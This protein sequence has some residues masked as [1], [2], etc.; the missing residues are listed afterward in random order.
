[1]PGKSTYIGK[2]IVRKHLLKLMIY[3]TKIQR[4]LFKGLGKS[5]ISMS[6]CKL[7]ELLQ[8]IEFSGGEIETY[9]HK[10][11]NSFNFLGEE[12]VCGEG[13]DD[14][15]RSAIEQAPEEYVSLP[16]RFDIN[17]YKM[18]EKFIDRLKDEKDATILSH[19]IRGKGAFRRFKDIVTTMG[20]SDNWYKFRDEHYKQIAID[21][22]D[23]NDIE[24]I[25]D[26]NS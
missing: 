24:Y 10:P 23:D 26:E 18:M 17:E 2:R 9:Y 8:N 11:T 5:E 20:L 21:W 4:T 3:S 7:S 1:M 19:S 22:C 12:L 6:K 14:A 16:S 13:D 15:L 25:D